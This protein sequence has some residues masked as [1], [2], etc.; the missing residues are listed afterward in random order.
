MDREHFISGKHYD[1]AT[2]MGLLT[3]IRDALDCD[4]DQLL[5]EFG[6][7]LTA[8]KFNF[9]TKDIVLLPIGG[10]AS[11]ERWLLSRCDLVGV[12]TPGFIREV[13]AAGY[14]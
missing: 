12:I 5:H 14:G 11:L 6:H 10:I 4:M 2:T 9:K 13:E 8:L 1:D 3:E 7:A